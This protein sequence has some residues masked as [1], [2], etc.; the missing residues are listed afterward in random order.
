MQC[1]LLSCAAWFYSMVLTFG[2]ICLNQI[3]SINIIQRNFLLI[4]QCVLW[5]VQS[6]PIWVFHWPMLIQY[7]GKSRLPEMKRT[8]DKQNRPIIADYNDSQVI[9]PHII[10]SQPNNSSFVFLSTHKNVFMPISQLISYQLQNK[11][12]Y[13]SKYQPKFQ[14]GCILIDFT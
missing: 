8:P 13:H 2:I 6:W 10:S 5:W 12:N 7:C 11:M 14:Q 9:A 4:A 3:I 1:S